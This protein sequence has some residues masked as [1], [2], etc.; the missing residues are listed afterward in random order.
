MTKRPCSG[1]AVF[2]AGVFRTKTGITG[3]YPADSINLNVDISRMPNLK[4]GIVGLPNVGKSTLFN[5]L[6]EAA[7][8]AANYP[9]CTVDPNVGV[10][11]LPDPRLDF[12]EERIG[13]KTK[14]PT[15]VTF[16]DIAGLVEGASE[17]EGLGNR[18]LANI[19]EVDAIVHVV[20]CFHDPDVMHVLGGVDPVRDREIINTELALADMQSVERRLARV[21]K[22][23]RSGDREA[24]KEEAL[25]RR[26][27]EVLGRGDPARLVVP[28]TA[29]E[30]RLLRTYQLLTRKPELYVANVTE[31]D[32]LAAGGSA[33]KIAAQ[34][35]YVRA[36]RD[37]IDRDHE[38]AA[39]VAL[40]AHMEA[41]ILALDPAERQEYLAD[42]GLDEPGL[43]RLIH[44]GY[45]LL[46]LISFFTAGPNEVRAWTVRRGTRAAQAAGEIH[47]DFE[48]GFI[49]AE[50]I[51][52]EDFVTAGSEKAA[53]EQG[54]MRSEGRDYTVADGDIILFRFNV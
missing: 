31:D 54:V 42:H 26:L 28:D 5:A 10:V 2:V 20:R 32:V 22:T 25:L 12:L 1:G 46:G 7:A 48:R 38:P 18:F 3:Y 49:R 44:A 6:T 34:N 19:R 23:A 52:W 37:A 30:E 13:S 43:F 24:K 16:V 35:P 14:V 51:G 45:A 53:R 17:G 27:D 21:E 33:E 36:L 11:E 15:T 41:E 29:E 47:T 39:M 9:F 8:D 40:A 50:T 4:L